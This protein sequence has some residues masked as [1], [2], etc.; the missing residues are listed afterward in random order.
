MDRNGNERVSGPVEPYTITLDDDPIV[1][2]LIEA[3][4][5]TPTVAFPSAKALLQEGPALNPVAIF[6]D[7]HLNDES[8]IAALPE[9]RQRWRY[10]PVIV[11]TADPD[12]KALADALTCGADDFIMKPLRP[13]E[14]VARL[15]ARLADQALKQN[16]Q[17]VRYG[18]VQL[19]QGYRLLRG[20]KGE[21][22][23]S[24]T[25]MN[26]LLALMRSG[27]TTLERSMLKNQC[28]DHIAV[29]DNALD[30]K[31]FEVRR[32]LLD[33]GS[34]CTIGTTYGVGFYLEAVQEEARA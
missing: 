22:Y 17:S 9:I 15:Q 5:G 8:G 29:S 14:V 33:V 6:V 7:V 24:P 16:T 4:L 28:W 10:C 32:A 27:G 34:T 18:D 13:R 23:L 25:E 21:R 3:A 26:L 2:K 30:R 31:I 11:I 20:P 1:A 12:D 19:D